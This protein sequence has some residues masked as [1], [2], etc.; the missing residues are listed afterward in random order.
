MYSVHAKST[1]ELWMTLSAEWIRLRMRTVKL[2]SLSAA[3]NLCCSKRKVGHGDPLV[4]NAVFLL[5]LFDSARENVHSLC[6]EIKKESRHLWSLFVHLF[7]ILL[8][9]VFRPC[10]RSYSLV[11]CLLAATLDR[12]WMWGRG[13]KQGGLRGRSQHL[14]TPVSKQKP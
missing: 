11:S 2:A 1:S 3:A 10:A 4:S 8:V 5:F 6:L 9:W 7:F 14:W 13:K 12:H